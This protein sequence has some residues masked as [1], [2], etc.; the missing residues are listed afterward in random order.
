MKKTEGMLRS[1]DTTFDNISQRFLVRLNE[2]LGKEA[3]VT[4]KHMKKL[5]KDA[6][7]QTTLTGLSQFKIY[8]MLVTY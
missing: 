4:S 8:V 5:K 6:V 2:I 3:I 1:S 7:I